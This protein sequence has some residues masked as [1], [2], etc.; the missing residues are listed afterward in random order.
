M[1]ISLKQVNRLT[2]L[3]DDLLDVSRIESGKISFSFAPVQIN[4][5]LSEIVERFSDQSQASRCEINLEM[6]KYPMVVTD[7][8]RLDQ[9]ITNLLSN[10]VKYGERSAINIILD[11]NERESIITVQDSGLGIP[12]D[13]LAKIFERFERAVDPQEISGLGLGLYISRTIIEALHGTITVDSE[14][15]KGSTFTIKIPLHFS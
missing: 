8:F 10:A 7:S 6:K 2:G 15:G 5:L 9:V 14:L 4:E 1:K 13:K 11:A 3:I 12:Q